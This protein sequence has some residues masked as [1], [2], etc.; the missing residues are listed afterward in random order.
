MNVEISLVVKSNVLVA[1]VDFEVIEVDVIL[2]DV[3][4]VELVV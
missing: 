1:D 4:V 2:D 3:E